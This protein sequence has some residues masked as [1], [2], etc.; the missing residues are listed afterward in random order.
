MRNKQIYFILKLLHGVSKEHFFPICF[1]CTLSA[2]DARGVYVC[3]A[4][5]YPVIR[6]RCPCPSKTVGPTPR[7][8]RRPWARS[9]IPFRSLH[10]H[11]PSFSSLPSPLPYPSSLFHFVRKRTS[12]EKKNDEINSEGGSTAPSRRSLPLSR[13][14]FRFYGILIYY[15]S[16]MATIIR[17]DY[18]VGKN[19]PI[20]DPRK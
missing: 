6:D 1:P 3:L 7:F 10:P 17:K 9:C 11:R 20:F 4:S 8:G 12:R 2:R 18:P 15:T 14:W 5:V 16:E 19:T 13:S